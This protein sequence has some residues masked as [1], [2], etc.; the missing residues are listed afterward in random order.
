[1]QITKIASL[2]YAVLYT[3]YFFVIFVRGK[4]HPVVSGL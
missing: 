4:N 2:L 3:T 1:M